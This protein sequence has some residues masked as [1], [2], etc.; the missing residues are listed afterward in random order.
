MCLEVLSALSALLGGLYWLCRLDCIVSSGLYRWIISYC[1]GWIRLYRIVLSRS[2]NTG[3]CA[4]S[5]YFLDW[6]DGM[7]GLDG[8]LVVRGWDGRTLAGTRTGAPPLDLEGRRAMRSGSWHQL[9][10]CCKDAEYL[11]R[12]SKRI[13]IECTQIRTSNVVQ[14][15][16]KSTYDTIVVWLH[17]NINCTYNVNV[18][19][20]KSQKNSDTNI[21]KY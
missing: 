16:I 18:Q 20:K 11:C 9:C 5:G 17:T 13:Q 3:L 12:R 15:T 7:D 4:L 21:A 2:G 6:M 19:K 14:D 1:I 8:A 10:Q